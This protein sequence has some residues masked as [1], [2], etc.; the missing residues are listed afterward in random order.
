MKKITVFEGD[1]IGPEVVQAACKILKATKAP[2]AFDYQVA[3]KKAFE[4]GFKTGVTDAAL[5]SIY[6]NK[7]M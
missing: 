2:L 4:E 1:G 3:G 7:K 5:E 6:Q